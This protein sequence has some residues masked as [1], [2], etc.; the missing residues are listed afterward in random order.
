MISTTK[1]FPE[2]LNIHDAFLKKKFQCIRL[3]P[4]DKEIILSDKGYWNCSKEIN[5]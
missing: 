5:E 1:L 3:R 2:L 4:I